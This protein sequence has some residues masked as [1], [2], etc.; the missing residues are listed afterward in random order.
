MNKQKRITKFVVI[1]AFLL[2]V[3]LLGYTFAKYV[4]TY[5]MTL[6]KVEENVEPEPPVDPQPPVEPEEPTVDGVV[7]VDKV[8]N[9]ADVA[10]AKADGWKMDDNNYAEIAVENGFVKYNQIGQCALYKASG[11]AYVANNGGNS[12]PLMFSLPKGVVAVDEENGTEII[13]NSLNLWCFSRF[14]RLAALEHV[15]HSVPDEKQTHTA[16]VNNACLFQY[17][18]KVRCI[19]EGFLGSDT[20]VAPEC[21]L[22]IC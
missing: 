20:N 1:L 14:Y 10:A 15:K 2:L 13:N 7:L 12:K 3:I 4:K 8:F 16:C 5:T 9:Y 22:V 19:V 6:A 18:E 21:N 11:S 17:R